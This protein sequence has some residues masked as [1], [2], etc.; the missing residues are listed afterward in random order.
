MT[1]Q[2]LI[3]AA[4]ALALSQTTGHAADAVSH[5]VSIEFGA[6][7][8]AADVWTPARYAAARPLEL[9]ITD[10]DP[11]SLDRES[12]GI[13][14]QSGFSMADQP[15]LV[16]PT[17]EPEFLFVPQEDEPPVPGSTTGKRLPR[18]VTAEALRPLDVGVFHPNAR[19]SSQRLVPLDADLA[20]PYRAVG[21]LFFTIPGS[22]EGM[23]SAAI[24]AP[25]LVLTAGH[26][27]HAG[28]N[29][30]NGWFANFRFIPSYR[31][32]TAPYGTWSVSWVITTS[33][34]FGGGGAVPNAGDFAIL[35]IQDRSIDGTTLRIGD[36]LGWLGWKTHALA[37][38]HAHLLGYPGN[39]DFGEKMHQ[40]TAQSWGD[41][42]NNTALYGSD[43]AGGSSGGPWVSN[44]GPPA[45]GQTGGLDP[46]RNQ[47]IGVTSFGFVDPTQQV[48]GSSV[49]DQQFYNDSG[50]GIQNAACGRQ[51][52][53]C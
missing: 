38:N 48:Q 3:A 17:P 24:I 5:G 39:H 26:C 25:R 36:Y 21:K 35:E 9:P 43:M 30:P 12:T 20:Y 34:W 6:R 31:D 1:R 33:A 4:V 10:F 44:F 42:A 16:E 18:Q 27:V 15:P 37:P 46:A 41:Y 14:Q 49:L 13:G 19:F 2:T 32:G 7:Q 23:C 52:G 11:F 45:D 40:V 28:N 50:T 47:V 8:L 51:P 53:N 29:S 22:G